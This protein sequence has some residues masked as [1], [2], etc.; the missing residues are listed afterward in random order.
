MMMA[1]IF[2]MSSREGITASIGMSPS[3]GMGWLG[4]SEWDV[5]AGL[6]VVEWCGVGVGSRGRLL[7]GLEIGGLGGDVWESEPCLS[8]LEKVLC[9][10]RGAWALLVCRAFF[11]SCV[12]FLRSGHDMAKV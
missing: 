3:I 12:A 5:M 6:V 10:M 1:V 9:W 8:A 7:F 2:V 11:F 4:V